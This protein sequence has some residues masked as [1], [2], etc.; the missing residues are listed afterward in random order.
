[1]LAVGGVLVGVAIAAAAGRVVT[2][3][4]YEVNA[5]D[6]LVIAAATAIVIAI[7]AVAVV[8]PAARASAINPADTFRNA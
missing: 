2:G 1:M 3:Q 5:R 8:I 7:V 4:L 6:P